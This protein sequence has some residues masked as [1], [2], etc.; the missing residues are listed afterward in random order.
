[1]VKTSGR[2]TKEGSLSQ[3]G[4]TCNR[5]HVYRID[6]HRK[7]TIWTIMMTKSW[8]DFKHIWRMW[9]IEQLQVSPSDRT[10]ATPHTNTQEA[11]L[12]HTIHTERKGTDTHTRGERERDK[13][14]G[15]IS[16]RMKIQIQNI[17]KETPT[18][19]GE[20]EVPGRPM[21]QYRE[22]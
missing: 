1:M 5:C 14:R 16:W 22:A 13:R 3:N 17:C 20:R 19:S 18:A 11:K 15:W 7:I 12:K 8:T 4:Q 9:I 21:V 2:A 6:Q 10:W